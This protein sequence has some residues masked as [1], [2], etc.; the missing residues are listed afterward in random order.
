MAEEKLRIHT[1]ITPETEEKIRAAM[2][3]ANCQSRNEFLEKALLFYCDYLASED[4]TEFLPPIFVQ[5]MRA[6][7]ERSED[8]ISR[9]L[10][11]LAVEQDMMMNVLA[12]GLEINSEELDALRGRCVRDVKRTSGAISFKDAVK[13]QNRED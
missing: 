11:K 2:V 6:T 3:K 9:L 1:R 7:I 5:A 10:F 12:A 13:Y 8:R 4:L